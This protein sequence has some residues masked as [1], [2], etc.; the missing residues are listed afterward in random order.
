MNRFLEENKPLKQCIQRLSHGI[1]KEDVEIF[2][3]FL[4]EL[5]A[6]ATENGLSL[7]GERGMRARGEATAIRFV[8]SL[9]SDADEPDV[10][11]DPAKTR[12]KYDPFPDFPKADL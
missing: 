10:E 2:F 3:G 11:L 4:Q 8:C 7:E 12:P 1:Q 6:K 5:A 9:Y